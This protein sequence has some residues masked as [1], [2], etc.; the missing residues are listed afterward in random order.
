MSFS[1][2]LSFLYSLFNMT[3]ALVNGFFF[4]KCLFIRVFMWIMWCFNVAMTY[5]FVLV[6]NIATFCLV[7]LVWLCR[8]HTTR[9]IRCCFHMLYRFHTCAL[10]SQF[11]HVIFLSDISHDN[12]ILRRHLHTTYRF[13]WH[14]VPP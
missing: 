3:I 9:R 8:S 10:C 12:V 11:R 13:M 14:V 5:I 6:F 7:L 1:T 2:R 4:V